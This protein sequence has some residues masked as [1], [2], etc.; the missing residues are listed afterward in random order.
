MSSHVLLARATQAK[1]R[2]PSR[3]TSLSRINWQPRARSTE[4]QACAFATQ[5]SAQRASGP[6]VGT[7]GEQAA[8]AIASKANES[9]LIAVLRLLAV[10]VLHL[11][12]HVARPD[13]R[14]RRDKRFERCDVLRRER[15][16]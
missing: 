16:F 15:L 12:L 5:A 7:R 3:S 14:R 8:S 13:D 11:L 6:G 9:T 10:E 2:A 1:T 4:L